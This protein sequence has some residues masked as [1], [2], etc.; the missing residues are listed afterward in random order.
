MNHQ[1]GFNHMMWVRVH[2]AECISPY[3]LYNKDLQQNRTSIVMSYW[4]ALT[5][6]SLRPQTQFCSIHSVQHYTENLL[7][8]CWSV[9]Y[10]AFTKDLLGYA[11]QDNT[12]V[13]NTFTHNCCFAPKSQNSRE[14]F[15]F[16]F[17]QIWAKSS[18]HVL[19]N[20]T[21][22]KK[23]A[24]GHSVLWKTFFSCLGISVSHLARDMKR[25]CSEWSRCSFREHLCWHARCLFW[26]HL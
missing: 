25:Y 18:S 4:L 7:H 6:P 11:L 20:W 5:S 21:T 17:Y 2:R 1:Q 23:L 22:C 9:C 15:L 19:Y 10:K 14:K 13:N 12:R 3:Y 16:C 24:N 26:L 8:T